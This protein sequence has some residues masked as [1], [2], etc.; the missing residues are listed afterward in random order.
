[1]DDW[2]YPEPNSDDLDPPSSQPVLVDEVSGAVEDRL[3]AAHRGAAD[4][5]R[6][7]VWDSVADGRSTPLQFESPAHTSL[8]Y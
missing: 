4:I 2:T 3:R 8:A 5:E 1:M 6:S 7:W